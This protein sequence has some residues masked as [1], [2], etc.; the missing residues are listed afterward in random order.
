MLYL[1]KFSAASSYSNLFLAGQDS[2]IPRNH[3]L[4]TQKLQRCG[5]ATHLVGKWHCGHGHDWMRPENRG[6]DSFFGYL[7]G[8]EDHYTRIQLQRKDW[9]GVDFSDGGKPSNATWGHYGSDLYSKKVQE[10]L[11]KQTGPFFLYYSMQNVHYP[12]QVG[13]FVLFYK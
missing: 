9:Y 13:Y 4:F 6:F 12:L 2:G 7:Q 3:E 8:A 5:Y 1:V 10:V 11:D